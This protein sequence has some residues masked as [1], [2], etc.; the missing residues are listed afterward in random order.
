MLPWS[1]VAVAVLAAFATVVAYRWHASAEQTGE[2]RLQIVTAG[3]S[4]DLTLSPDGRQLV[5][6]GANNGDPLSLRPLDSEVAKPLPG[7][8]SGGATFWSPDSKSVGFVAHEKLKRIDLATGAV[9]TLADAP[10]ERGASWNREGTILFA[11]GG[12]GPLYRIPATGG[13]PVQVT[14]LRTPQEA[15]QRYPQFLPDGH[16]FLFWIVGSPD[17]EG[18]SVGSLD[19]QEHQRVCVADGPVTFVPPDHLFLVRESVVYAQR[20]DLDQMKLTGEP[21][22]VASGVS[23]DRIYRRRVAASDTGIFAF[24]PDVSVKRQVIAQE[25]RPGQ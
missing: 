16:H 2:L 21:V 10:V 11:P 7:T 9:Q 5:S 4:D 17:A 20:F 3:S 18:E 23:E 12:N 24:R 13:Q 22:A 19:N 15:S 25:N 6:S 14:R 8:E 1:I